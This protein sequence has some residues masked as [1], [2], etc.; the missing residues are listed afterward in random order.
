M[1]LPDD[2]A[3]CYGVPDPHGLVIIQCCNCLRR[4]APVRDDRLCLYMVP[5]DFTTTCPERIAP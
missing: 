2:Y 5:P 3:R 1:T 4:T